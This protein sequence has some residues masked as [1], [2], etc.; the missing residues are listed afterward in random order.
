[1]G[2]AGGCTVLP[3]QGWVT[4]TMAHPMCG[5]MLQGYCEVHLWVSGRRMSLWPPGQP[6]DWTGDAHGGVCVCECPQLTMEGPG[7]VATTPGKEQLSVGLG[8]A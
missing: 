2:L 1:M 4:I 5:Q 6:Q 8:T 3:D 7:K